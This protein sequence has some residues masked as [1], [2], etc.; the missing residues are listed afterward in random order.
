MGCLV[1]RAKG[2][3]RHQ[4]TMRWR[5]LLL[6]S[7][8]PFLQHPLWDWIDRR[9]SGHRLAPTD[10]SAI[11]PAFMQ[12]MRHGERVKAMGGDLSDRPW[13]NGR[14]MRIA[15]LGRME[16]SEHRLSA[17]AMGLE[18]RDPTGDRRLIEFCLAVP[19]NQYLRDGQSRWLLRRLMGETLPPEI[20]QTQTRGYQSADWYEATAAAIPRIH[21]E[22]TR[23][24]AKGVDRYLDLR[25]LEELLND[26]PDGGWDE[27]RNRHLY[28]TKLLRGMSVGSFIRQTQDGDR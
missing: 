4:P 6:Q 15:L 5:G 27:S 1:A 14:R 2:M 17:N 3:K 8:A 25:G 21:E 28:R 20:L 22:L 12:R 24:Q 23:Q 26:W 19:V 10:Y 7:V 9:L 16:N 11:H 13:A 18:T